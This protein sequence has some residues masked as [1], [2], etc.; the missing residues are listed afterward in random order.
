MRINRLVSYALLAFVA[1]LFLSP[2]LFA[3][4][5]ESL[6]EFAGGTQGSLVA[7]SLVLSTALMFGFFYFLIFA[8]KEQR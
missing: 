5:A 8:P 4:T 1:V 3:D 7:A 6:G 2:A